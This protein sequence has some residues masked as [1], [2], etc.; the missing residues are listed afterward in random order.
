MTSWPSVY[1]LASGG[2]ELDEV[3]ARGHV[4][5]G[6]VARER[7]VHL[8]RVDLAEGELHGAVAVAR[9]RCGPGSRRW[10]RP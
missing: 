1:S 4:G 5:L 8:A 10:G 3:A 2:A 7:L 9:R 6:E